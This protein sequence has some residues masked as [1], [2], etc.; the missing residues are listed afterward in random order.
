[1]KTIHLQADLHAADLWL[2]KSLGFLSNDYQTTAR[3]VEVRC[4]GVNPVSCGRE[5]AAKSTV[6]ASVVDYG[7]LDVH[8]SIEL[9]D[10]WEP[11]DTSRMS[12]K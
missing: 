3:N 1:M 5:P 11:T 8:P 2:L 4:A 6:P 12:R 10:V 7:L 9:L